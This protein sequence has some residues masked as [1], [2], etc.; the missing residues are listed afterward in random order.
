MLLIRRICWLFCKDFTSH[1]LLKQL[2]FVPSW[3]HR[4]Q[5]ARKYSKISNPCFN[6]FV[7][8]WPRRSGCEYLKRRSRITNAT[9]WSD[10][11]AISETE[12]TENLKGHKLESRVT[13]SPARVVPGSPPTLISHWKYQQANIFRKTSADYTVQHAKNYGKRKI[14]NLR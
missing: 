13:L 12:M 3:R 4:T 11:T 6:G 9:F 2:L 5:A 14:L 7:S 1:F 8:L 10:Q